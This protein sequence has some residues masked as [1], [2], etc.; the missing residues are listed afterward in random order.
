MSGYR[1]GRHIGVPSGD[2]IWV[3]DLGPGL[4]LGRAD[5]RPT[6]YSAPVTGLHTGPMTIHH[7]GTQ[8][9]VMVRLTPLGARS[10]FGVRSAD[11][12]RPTECAELENPALA[13]AVERIRDIGRQASEVT[14]RG[15]VGDGNHDGNLRQQLELLAL[16]LLRAIPDRTPHSI[17]LDLWTLLRARPALRPSALAKESGWS[18]RHVRT[19]LRS[20]VGL[21]PD[22][23]HR[24]LRFERS[25]TGVRPG[26][27]LAR[28]AARYG[29]AD[30]AHLSRE[31]RRYLGMSPSAYL[32]LREFEP[33]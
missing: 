29:Y 6:V 4:N 10:F 12:L 2:L 16:N 3:I 25:F 33:A 28:L 9:G 32:S 17:G 1:P 31:W 7:D 21:G 5:D 11:L 15:Q 14:G 22:E 30:Q 23:V 20:E 27:N 13:D 26:A 19:Q 24:L 18:D 8:H